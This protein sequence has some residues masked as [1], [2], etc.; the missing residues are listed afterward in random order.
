GLDDA[1]VRRVFRDR[2]RVAELVE[3]EVQR[4]PRGHG[5]AVGAHG[6]AV[7][8]EDRDLDVCVAVRGV[9]E[10]GDLVTGHLR[11]RAVA[12]AGDVSF[13]DGPAPTSDGFHGGRSGSGD[14]W[15]A[16]LQNPYLDPAAPRRP[17][18]SP[19]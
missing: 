15:T 6:L 14:V 10:A 4:P 8:I 9:E 5:H 2:L 18:R 17:T 12:P 7:G 16:A 3:A 19:P 13:G 11:L 1:R